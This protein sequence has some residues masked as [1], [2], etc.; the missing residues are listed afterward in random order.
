MSCSCHSQ[1]LV[2]SG[3]ISPL[4]FPVEWTLSWQSAPGE[5][6]E[7]WKGEGGGLEGGRMREEPTLKEALNEG[8][9]TMWGWSGEDACARSTWSSAV[10]GA[11][12]WKSG[13]NN[14]DMEC[15]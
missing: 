10:R 15:Y 3:G 13:I 11:R 14:N 8:V 6:E 7:G 5:R 1:L 12:S 2:W 9:S 4:V